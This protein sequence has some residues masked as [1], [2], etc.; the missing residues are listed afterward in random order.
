MHSFS[1][2]TELTK[3]N[4]IMSGS[5]K[6]ETRYYIDSVEYTKNNI[7]SASINGSLY[8]SVTIGRAHV[9]TLEMSLRNIDSDDIATGAEIRV[10]QRV[11]NSSTSSEWIKRGT[12]YLAKRVIDG[13]RLNLTAYDKLYSADIPFFSSGTW[14]STTALDVVKNMV[15]SDLG[16]SL[17]SST[18]SL[19]TNTPVTIPFVPAMGATSTTDREMLE[20]VG[21]AYG[22]NWAIND[23]GELQLFLLNSLDTSNAIEVGLNCKSLNTAKAFPAIDRVV[24]SSGGAEYRYPVVSEATWEAMTGTILNASNPYASSE[25]AQAI[26][27]AVEGFVYQG[28]EASSSFVGPIVELGDT[29]HVGD[30]YAV[31]ASQVINISNKSPNDLSAQIITEAE[32]ADEYKYSTP[33]E[34]TTARVEA[35]TQAS[36]AVLQDQINLKVDSSDFEA[37]EATNYQ[38]ITPMYLANDGT[39]TPSVDDPNW[40]TTPPALQEG[41]HMWTMTVYVRKNGVTSYSAPMDITGTEG[42]AG[43]GIERVENFY[44]VSSSGDTAPSTWPAAGV[45]PQMTVTNRFLWGYETTYY[46]DNTNEST[47][48]HVI[49]VYGQTGQ[50][51]QDGN[52]AYNYELLVSTPVIVKSQAGAYNPASIT[53]TSRR[54]QGTGSPSNYAGRFKIESTTNN[55][56]WTSVYTSSSNESTKTYS[57]PA[58]IVALRCSLYLA[59]GTTTLLD[60]QSVPI[61]L[62]G[63]D[64]S[65]GEDG[66][67]GVDGKDAYTVLL[68]NENHSFAAGTSAAIAAEI[69]VNVIAYKGATQ[70]AATI[71][72]I[73]GQVTGLTT[74]L[75]NNGTT[76]AGFKV[77]VTTSLTTKSGQLTIP[78]TVDGKSFTK[79]FT[80]SLALAGQ[81]GN[82]AYNYELIVSNPVIVK[83][84]AGAYNPTSIVLTA[85]RGQGTGSPANYSGRFKIESTTN[86]STWTSVYTSSSNEATRTQ[87]VPN[88]IIALR[89]S[90]YLAG[91]TTTLLDQQTVPIVSDGPTGPQ[92]NAGADGYTVLLSNENHSFAAGTSA[93]TATNITVNV[94]AYKGATQIAATIGTIT[95]QVTGLTTSLVNNG[96]TS[97]GFKVTVTTSLTTK[98]GQLTIPVTVDGK[99]FTKIFSWSLAL[100]GQTGA[101]GDDG[102]GIASITEYYGRSRVSTTEP[103]ASGDA[104][105]WST[106]YQTVDST[107][108]FLWNYEVVAYTDNTSFTSQK[109]IIGTYAQDGTD[110]RNPIAFDQYLCANEDPDNPPAASANWIHVSQFNLA[111]YQNDEDHHYYIWTKTK[112]TWDVGDPTWTEPYLDTYYVNVTSQFDVLAGSIRSSVSEIYTAIGDETTAREELEE[113]VNGYGERIS[114]VESL[115]TT[116]TQTAGGLEAITTRVTNVEGELQ[117]QAN[118]MRWHGD[119]EVPYLEIG[120]SNASVHTE[121][122][123]DAF[124]VVSGGTD[125]MVADESG[126]TARAFKAS[127]SIDIG[128]FRWVDE[129]SLGFSLI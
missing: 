126:V 49:G 26:Y 75:V 89:C 124:A 109:R 14:V 64:G 35:Q 117:E 120:Q 83:S 48:P 40:S 22:G 108:K 32:E 79:I 104:G 87:S 17:E 58:N 34:R 98:S 12:F 119:A 19:L 50:A 55:S 112:T 20:Y 52:D 71:G 78:I 100:T 103:T 107:W 94:L 53:L 41:E 69:T 59:G 6:V 127:E 21:T 10:E 67:D 8:D 57:V 61:V 118:Y 101:E 36:I 56:T 54:S 2:S 81:D 96:S 42:V 90:L 91:G 86:N 33:Q 84:E 111:D 85:K 28:Y 125:S 65:D 7:L 24:V 9:R 128:N 37:A 63:I 29:I 123:G 39:R 76:S 60:Q 113:T 45:I 38:S 51:G 27:T 31:I 88:N 121:M 74:S 62:D 16:I 11:S 30:I 92:G 13:I 25:L 4:N 129:G 72:T 15:C 1:S 95:G 66:R 102:V 43:R 97:A 46:T 47:T 70:T 77:T 80:W 68:S 18:E 73:S 114:A 105:S 110:G 44:Q 106:T 115:E 93:A 122:R 116:V 23:D 5:Y 99:S 3:Y 82:D